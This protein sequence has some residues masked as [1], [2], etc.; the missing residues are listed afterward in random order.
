MDEKIETV[1][2]FLEKMVGLEED[3]RHSEN[4]DQRILNLILNTLEEYAGQFQNIEYN[5]VAEKEAIKKRCSDI[6]IN[7]DFILRIKK[8]KN[9]NF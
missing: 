6:I 9:F 1:K 5:F 7:N 8:F 4:E 2:N 3:I